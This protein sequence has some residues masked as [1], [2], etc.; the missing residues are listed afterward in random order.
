MQ[1]ISDTAKT[2]GIT[3]FRAQIKVTEQFAKAF[4]GK[5]TWNDILRAGLHA[6]GQK[7]IAE[8]L[9]LRFTS[10]AMGVLGYHARRGTGHDPLVHTGRLRADALANSSPEARVTSG[11]ATLI[12][13]IS[14]P[15]MLDHKGNST[16]YGYSASPIVYDVLKQITDRE[17]DVIAAE[18]QRTMLG[19]IEGA[20]PSV[21]RKGTVKGALTQTQ[22]L[23]INH[24]KRPQGATKTVRT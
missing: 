7:W 14:T 13:H 8:Y 5:R 22:R 20:T 17:V 3:G 12:L 2:T 24:T 4:F 1:E 23:S 18:C 19:L 16:G 11:N 9:P 6:G 21:S 15:T 10:Y